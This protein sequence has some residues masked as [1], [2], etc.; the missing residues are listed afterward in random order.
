[1]TEEEQKLAKQ[2]L[3][4]LDMMNQR[5]E[6][7]IDKLDMMDKVLEKGFDRIKNKIELMVDEEIKRDRNDGL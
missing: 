1:M 7:M 5:A 6:G 2:I 3:D 4:K